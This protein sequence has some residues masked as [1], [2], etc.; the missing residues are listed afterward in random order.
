MRSIKILVF[1]NEGFQQL[2]MAREYNIYHSAMRTARSI[3]PIQTLA[4]GYELTFIDETCFAK[5]KGKNI[6]NNE[7]KKR[8]FFVVD[9]FCP[10]KD[11]ITVYPITII[12]FGYLV[13][14]AEEAAKKYRTSN[15]FVVRHW[16]VDNRRHNWTLDVSV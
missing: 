2:Q 16:Y 8:K 9:F 7:G 4:W 14:D 10:T 1:S 3:Y 6:S 13:F 15:N 11:L 5:V 12:S